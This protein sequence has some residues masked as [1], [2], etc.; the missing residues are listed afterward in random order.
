MSV[1]PNSAASDWYHIGSMVGIF[2]GFAL[3][4]A[5]SNLFSTKNNPANKSAGLRKNAYGGQ[6]LCDLEKRNRQQKEKL[7]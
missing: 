6:T 1:F 5:W 7:N 2:I 3:A 4:R